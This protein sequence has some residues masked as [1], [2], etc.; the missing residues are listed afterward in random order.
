MTPGSNQNSIEEIFNSALSEVL[1]DTRPGW[2]KFLKSEKLK[3]L[4]E[5][6]RV[7]VLLDNP[8]S[9]PI[10][11]ECSSTESD[12]NA[13]AIKRLGKQLKNSDHAITT[14]IAVVI[15]RE[16][17]KGAHKDIV[18]KL[19]RKRE[20]LQYA[21]YTDS[22]Q[23]RF[24]SSG[25]IEGDVYDLADFIA[26]SLLPANVAETAV[27]AL[28]QGA[29]DISGY[30]SD[31]GKPVRNRIA[32]LLR[33]NKSNWDQTNKI[34]GLIMINALAYQQ[35]LAEIELRVKDITDMRDSSPTQRI[36]K[37]IVIEA[38]DAILDI[39]YWPIFNIA[40]EILK[41]VPNQTAAQL[42]EDAV[43]TADSIKHTIRASDVAGSVFQRLMADRKMLATFYTRPESAL[44]AAHLAIPENLDWGKQETMCNYRIADY[45]CGTGGLL[46][47]AYQRVCELAQRH[48]NRNPG[49][50]HADMMANAIT[51]SDI[52]P[53]A[54]HSTAILLSSV[55][56]NRKYQNTRYILYDFG[57]TGDKDKKG[58]PEVGIGALKLLGLRIGD[59]SQFEQP[60]S[61]KAVGASGVRRR[62]IEVEMEPLSQDL[63]IMNPPFT[64]QT[65]HEGVHKDTPN[66]QFAALQTTPEEQAAMKKKTKKLSK[67]TIGDG[68]AG[69]GSQ[70]AA[71]AHNMVKPG[72][73]I[74]LI[75]PIS[76]MQGGNW[77][78]KKIISWQKLRQ[79]LVENYDQIVVITIT[80]KDSSKGSFSA[81]TK[82]REA[83]VIAR[84]RPVGEQVSSRPL[85]HFVNLA[86]L[87]GNVLEAREYAR[88][89]RRTVTNLK[90]EGAIDTLQIGKNQIGEVIYAYADPLDKWGMT[91]VVNLGLI[92]TASLLKKGH[93]KLP[94]RV[95]MLDIPMAPIGS[96]ANVCLSHRSANAYDRHAGSNSG[97]EYPILW[98]NRNS[99]TRAYLEIPPD[100]FG[101]VKK[102]QEEEMSKLWERASYLHIC[103]DFRF[104]SNPTCAVLT[105]QKSLWGR[106][107][108]NIQFETKDQ[109]K[110]ACV[111][112]NSTLG[113]LSYWANSNRTQG[114][115]GSTTVTAIPSITM[116]DVR[117][118]NPEQMAAAVRIYDSLKHKA[119]LP[120][121]EAHQDLVRQEL[122]RRLLIEVLGYDASTV[123]QLELLCHQWCLEP[124]VGGTKKTALPK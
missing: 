31:L 22:V 116:L 50:L 33:Q 82:T 84:R 71:I 75:L 7:D 16:I 29:N 96:I 20:R 27:K 72:G 37:D 85:G 53:A 19:K 10:A 109:E 12:A 87:P 124:S 61:G 30:L 6:G 15:P 24:P 13:D 59:I 41:S 8:S 101:T 32:K 115:R 58:R 69:L 9:S 122:D 105:P 95:N 66:P 103:N 26:P 62:V 118:L 73:Q 114:G 11:I 98:W 83:L 42:L 94:Q 23:N 106:A 54:V 5:G 64:R 78:G 117:Q 100:H 45:A 77:D 25:F 67:G 40:R 108:T 47:A 49:K 79:L 48:G 97:S 90:Q 28:E 39:N 74:A 107:W 102:G 112:F 60:L 52:L 68:N 21:L 56:P 93:L 2:K 80:H 3:T 57:Y 55:A 92:K 110:V 18:T 36:T 81:D 113:M 91:G 38:W 86:K 34:A 35:I 119:F 17:M 70:F 76:S 43:K 88:T 51:G 120:A 111:W 99:E 65:N 44:L 46:L 104:N 4:A 1:G 63:V 123:S 89:I 121:N 14:A